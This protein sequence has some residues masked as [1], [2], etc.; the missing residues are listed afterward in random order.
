MVA[1]EGDN[2]EKVAKSDE[3]P[4]IRFI[5][6]KSD[7]YK[8]EFINGAISNITPRGEI[9]CNFHF[10]SRDMP[11][12]QVAIRADDGSGEAKLSPFQ[13]PGTF[14]RDVKF[15][16]VI[17]VSFARDLVIMLNKKI[18]ECDAVL[19]ERVKDGEQK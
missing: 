11:T 6:T 1:Q 16:I 17:N 14:T 18:A 10:E 9:V 8:L 5:S 2:M 3:R 7:D 15:G 19:A 12:E 4:Q 13:D